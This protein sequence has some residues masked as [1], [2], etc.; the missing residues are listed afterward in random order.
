MTLNLVLF[1]LSK[2]VL[3]Y[4]IRVFFKNFSINGVTTLY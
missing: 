1:F 2:L 3:S 4:S